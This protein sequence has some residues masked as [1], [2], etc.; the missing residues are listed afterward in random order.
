MITHAWVSPRGKSDQST[1]PF[2]QLLVLSQDYIHLFPRL[3]Y[4][5][6]PALGKQTPTS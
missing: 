3:F 2:W 5:E 6:T 4:R 1:G